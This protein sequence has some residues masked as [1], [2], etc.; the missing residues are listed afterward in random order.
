MRTIKLEHEEWKLDDSSP[1]GKRGGFGQVF[2]GTSM[3]G[4]PV[5]IKLIDPNVGDAAHRELDFAKAFVRRATKHLIPILD[6]GTDTG[7]GQACIVMARADN[8][9]REYLVRAGN[10]SEQA[11]NEILLQIA[12]GLEEAGDWIHRDLKPENILHAMGRWQVADFGIARLAG[13]D[14][15]ARTLKEALSPPYAAPEQFDGRR[16][17]HTTD[18]YALGCIAFELLSGATPFRG[19][20]YDEFA[21]QHRHE[22]PVL[23]HGSALLRVLI[24]RMLA[25][26][27]SARPDIQQVIAELSSAHA[28]NAAATKGANRLAAASAFV[29]EEDAKRMA[30]EE[31]ARAE[32]QERKTLANHGAIELG[33]IADELFTRIQASAPQAK[34]SLRRPKPNATHV[35]NL[36]RGALT[37]AVGQWPQIPKETF[38]QSHW[39]VVCGGIISVESPASSRSASLWYAKRGAGAYEWVEVAYW[40]LSGADFSKLPCYLAP[41]RDA[42]FAAAPVMHVWSLAY[43]PRSISGQHL[44]SFCDRWMEYFALAAQNQLQRP[45]QLPEE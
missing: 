26:P 2:A 35:A 27:Q 8:N 11:V 18:V 3:T 42:D 5:A 17:T 19:P 34:I 25:K 21:E 45:S 28:K 32:Q 38:S 23:K 15:S 6:F 37:M 4:T 13:A 40:P 41:G 43:Q 44:D 9:L 22:L 39:D 24:V 20:G 10:P 14:T 29:A 12:K 16:A 33:A 36:G 7:L 30:V 31:A 1:L